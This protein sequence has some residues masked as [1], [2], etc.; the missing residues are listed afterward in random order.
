VIWAA[1]PVCCVDKC[2]RRR[3]HCYSGLEVVVEVECRESSCVFGV[4]MQG[5]IRQVPPGR[6]PPKRPPAH[7]KGATKPRY[8]PTISAN[9]MTEEQLTSEKEGT[10]QGAPASLI[11]SMAPGAAPKRW[12]RDCS[13][14]FQSDAWVV[15]IAIPNLKI[16]NLCCERYATSTNEDNV[17]MQRLAPTQNQV[18]RD[19][20][21]QPLHHRPDLET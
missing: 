10:T 7:Q 11:V 8:R 12:L 19:G 18:T 13:K 14:L 16:T 6:A 1:R 3:P 5:L 4:W 17:R 2:G 9:R 15:L 21:R 20:P